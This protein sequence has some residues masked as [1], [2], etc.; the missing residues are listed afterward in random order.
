MLCIH[1]MHVVHY[2]MCVVITISIH[3]VRHIR[4]YDLQRVSCARANVVAVSVEEELF[5]SAFSS[6]ERERERENH[7]DVRER[8]FPVF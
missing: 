5:T 1:N 6:R 7:N 4:M 8:T 2:N 3:L